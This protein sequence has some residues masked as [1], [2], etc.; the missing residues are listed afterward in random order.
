[1]FG[2][3]DVRKRDQS[4]AGSAIELREHV[5]LNPSFSCNDDDSEFVVA[6]KSITK[7]GADLGASQIERE[8][9]ETF[10]SQNSELAEKISLLEELITKLDELKGVEKEQNNQNDKL[11]NSLASTLLQ[12]Q[13]YSQSIR[14][15]KDEYV[16]VQ[17]HTFESYGPP[18]NSKRPPYPPPFVEKMFPQSFKLKPP[19]LNQDRKIARLR[20]NLVCY[21]CNKLGH[22]ARNCRS[23]LPTGQNILICYNCGKRNHIARNCRNRSVNLPTPST[24]RN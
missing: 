17:H 11:P 23:L 22:Y 21:R 7:N 15:H 1:M 16:Q 19:Q 20:Q 8:Q 10:S 9:E 2:N 6:I 14:L 4:S 3:G 12:H 5:D 24:L 13:N 18:G